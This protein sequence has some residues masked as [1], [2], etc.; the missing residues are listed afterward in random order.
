MV[1]EAKGAWNQ[2]L[3]AAMSK[4]LAGKYLKPDLTDQGVYLVFWFARADWEDYN[5]SERRRRN[6]ATRSDGAGLRS[7]LTKQALEVSRSHGVA[8][9][10][11]VIDGSLSG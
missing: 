9:A 10:A 1:I 7:I 11:I 3:M 8:I 6:R 4:Q 5:P 2:E